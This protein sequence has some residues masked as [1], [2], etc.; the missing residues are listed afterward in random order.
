MGK[1]ILFHFEIDYW[2]GN[3]MRLIVDCWI[4]NEINKH[5]SGREMKMLSI[6]NENCI[7]MLIAIISASDVMYAG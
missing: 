1:L 6:K 7:L 4:G 5:M 3:E 2:I